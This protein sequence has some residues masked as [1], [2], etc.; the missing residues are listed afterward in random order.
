[1][2]D[3][4]P[5]SPSL[6]PALL[7]LVRF[8]ASSGRPL[9]T[10]ISLSGRA[11]A[12]ARGTGR[13]DLLLEALHYHASVEFFA[14]RLASADSSSRESL[15][16]LMELG[17]GSPGFY[18]MG[19]DGRLICRLLQRHVCWY[20]GYFAEARA[21]RNEMVD[22]LNNIT[23][24]DTRGCTLSWLAALDSLVDD[25]EPA[26][27]CAEQAVSLGQEYEDAIIYLP[28]AKIVQGRERCRLGMNQTGISQITENLARVASCWHAFGSG[29]AAVS[30]L[31]A[32][33]RDDAVAIVDTALTE[34]ARTGI[35]YHDAELLRLRA[36]A[37][38]GIDPEGH[39]EAVGDTLHQGLAIARAQGARWLE[40]RVALSMVRLA[41]D[42]NQRDAAHTL[43]RVVTSFAASDDC[44]E[45][46]EARA[47]IARSK[48]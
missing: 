13:W 34:S 11:L 48:Y 5:D 9:A 14:G 18:M 47:G 6:I 2:C 35:R 8:F 33:H 7:G 22:L 20:M 3:R 46:L 29:F 43:E 1:L 12:Q 24:V 19:V 39:S 25:N 40:L 36:E 4:L 17:T 28:F 38:H 31:G 16:L 23:H 15:R 45:L 41:R 44:A 10:A 32:E 42:A 27:T 30:M 37:L 26:L 21:V